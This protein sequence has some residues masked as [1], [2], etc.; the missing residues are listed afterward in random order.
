M[1]TKN[2]VSMLQSSETEPIISS[3]PDNLKP[4]GK[5]FSML[6][7]G[8]TH[9]CSSSVAVTNL[10]SLA[11]SLGSIQ[12]EQVAS[13]LLKDKM[14]A[15]CIPKGATFSLSTGGN[16]LVVT[17]GCPANKA[18]R[19]TVKQVSLQVIKELQV[20]LEL[21]IDDTKQLI[22]SLRKGLGNKT[23]VEPNIFGKLND[24]EESISHFYNVEKVIY[25][26]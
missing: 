13:G 15:D 8:H 5:C 23:A 26:Y 12:A 25:K 14:K 16:P 19:R 20:I 1:L 17:V 4:C 7:P 21:S 3:S 6:A 22:S 10:I 9:N 11:K 2:S 24:L 18:N